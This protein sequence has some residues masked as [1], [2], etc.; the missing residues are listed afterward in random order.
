V[1]CCPSAR[2]APKDYLMPRVP[3]AAIAAT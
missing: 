3:G 2:N 1:R